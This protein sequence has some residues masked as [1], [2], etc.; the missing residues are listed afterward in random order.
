MCR[1]KYGAGPQYFDQTKIDANKEPDSAITNQL[2]EI[3]HKIAN[4]DGQMQ[5]IQGALQTLP[6]VKTKVDKLQVELSLALP[7]LDDIGVCSSVD[8][9][10]DNKNTGNKESVIAHKSGNQSY[11]RITKN[12]SDSI[13]TSV[14]ETFKQQRLLDR[15]EASVVIYGLSG[16]D[17]N[18]VARTQRICIMDPSSVFIEW[19]VLA[20]PRLQILSQTK[21]K[22][23]Q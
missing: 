19:V 20:V 13:K 11:A 23:D 21:P 18:D 17:D 9:P 12:I 14:A 7:K 16:R 5:K 4:I 3:R 15:D 10:T 1:D 8:Q 6:N 22:R 2:D